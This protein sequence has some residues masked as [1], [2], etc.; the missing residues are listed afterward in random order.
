MEYSDSDCDSVEDEP[1]TL[2]ELQTLGVLTRTATIPRP[3]GSGPLLKKIGMRISSVDTGRVMGAQ[4]TTIDKNSPIS[5]CKGNSTINVGDVLISVDDTPLIGKTFSSIMLELAECGQRS[6]DIILAVVSMA[7]L[8]QSGLTTSATL[9]DDSDDDSDDEAV[10]PIA[11]VFKH[12]CDSPITK[13]APPLPVDIPGDEV[14]REVDGGESDVGGAE[15]CI[16]PII[17]D[18]SSEPQ[19]SATV[20]VDNDTHGSDTSDDAVVPAVCIS[21]TSVSSGVVEL[22]CTPVDASLNTQELP[23]EEQPNSVLEAEICDICSDGA[24]VS[25][26]LNFTETTSF[27]A[28]SATTHIASD[29]EVTCTSEVTE[30]TPDDLAVAS[31]LGITISNGDTVTEDGGR[32]DTDLSCQDA[33]ETP[34]GSS[35]EKVPDKE[36]ENPAA[37]VED[38][39]LES[40]EAAPGESHDE[41]TFVSTH[42]TEQSLPTEESLDPIAVLLAA[43][44]GV[45]FVREQEPDLGT[46]TPTPVA[47]TP[48]V[49][50]GAGPAWHSND[51]SGVDSRAT[52]LADVDFPEAILEMTR[53][54][55]EKQRRLAAKQ[56]TGNKQDATS[57]SHASTKE[58]AMQ[59]S[60]GAGASHTVRK[61]SRK[62]RKDRN[63]GNSDCHLTRDD[64][65]EMAVNGKQSLSLRRR[66]QKNSDSVANQTTQNDAKNSTTPSTPAAPYA[67]QT[68][69]PLDKEDA[70]KSTSSHPRVRNQPAIQDS[71]SYDDVFGDNAK[72]SD[73]G[74]HSCSSDALTADFT[75]DFVARARAAAAVV[76]ELADSATREVASA[77]ERRKECV[78]EWRGMK[79][80]LVVEDADGEED[81]SAST[82]EPTEDRTGPTAAV[83]AALSGKHEQF[84]APPAAVVSGPPPTAPPLPRWLSS[85][86]LRLMRVR[87]SA[88]VGF[89]FKITRKGGCIRIIDVKKYTPSFLAGIQTGD[90]VLY[91]GNVSVLR[92]SVDKV[93]TVI[94]NA[95]DLLSLTVTTSEQFDRVYH[96]LD[97]STDDEDDADETAAAAMVDKS[98]NILSSASKGNGDHAAESAY[99]QPSS[100]SAGTSPSGLGGSLATKAFDAVRQ[101]TAR[102]SD[103][104]AAIATVGVGVSAGVSECTGND[105]DTEVSSHPT[106]V[107]VQG[108]EG[109]AISRTKQETPSTQVPS[110]ADSANST[111]DTDEGALAI[112]EAQILARCQDSARVV[113]IVRLP[114]DTSVGIRLYSPTPTWAIPNPRGI[115]ISKIFP[116]S[117]AHRTHNLVV[118]DVVLEVNGVPVIDASHR[119]VVE[120]INSTYTKRFPYL[121]NETATVKALDTRP[122]LNGKTVRCTELLDESTGTHLVIAPTGEEIAIAGDNL[123]PTNDHS[124]KFNCALLKVV[125]Q[126]EFDRANRELE[127]SAGTKAARAHRMAQARHGLGRDTGRDPT[128]G[129]ANDSGGS[130]AFDDIDDRR[131]ICAVLKQNLVMGTITQEEYDHLTRINQQ[132]LDPPPGA[133]PDTAPAVATPDDGVVIAADGGAGY[134]DSA[135]SPLYAQIGGSADPSPEGG[136]GKNSQPASILRMGKEWFKKKTDAMIKAQQ[137]QLQLLQQNNEK[138]Q[139]SRTGGGVSLKK[140]KGGKGKHNVTWHAAVAIDPE[141]QARMAT[142]SPTSPSVKASKKLTAAIERDIRRSNAPSPYATDPTVAFGGHAVA[143]HVVDGD[144]TVKL[145]PLDIENSEN[146]EDASATDASTTDASA[147]DA[148]TSTVGDESTPMKCKVDANGVPIR[149]RRKTKTRRRIIENITRSNPSVP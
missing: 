91:I 120:L 87:R 96:P 2:E 122:D 55:H 133:T 64:A 83:P 149:T 22:E 144:G 10:S 17:C 97:N 24:T 23:R 6:T 136:A 135:S 19:T 74:V 114:G 86:P 141:V 72:L 48:V 103:A 34:S 128:V 106:V 99:P 66:S 15:A 77:T 137:Q 61:K 28:I 43:T 108:N 44:S 148:S 124:D 38:S 14:N 134:S 92:S 126:L 146:E 39:V 46:P 53:E 85:V 127:L 147:T 8:D 130:G 71:A 27:G 12:Q 139:Q 20:V 76:Q 60:L 111:R 89:G 4:I 65:L 1:V 26:S 132:V 31:A 70:S 75:D 41:A 29:E 90:V 123:V 67:V 98:K 93:S 84:T 102:A 140:K 129:G 30:V 62:R 5:L 81:T 40:T 88:S 18:N 51:G 109:S 3:D 107:A 63:L 45:P 68:P 78:S 104:F 80:A 79:A 116:D 42:K 52:V 131:T 9:S 118:G 16:S 121:A 125:P 115:R 36:Q 117:P 119:D 95:G 59:I 37:D 113:R 21:T 32:P 94:R 138:R 73:D 110:M 142:L 7:E 112:P 57:Q 33:A 49:D 25:G 11:V 54:H 47:A 145:L 143:T 50:D 82:C 101:A 35:D 58:P 100:A 13:A 69:A 105:S 56:Q